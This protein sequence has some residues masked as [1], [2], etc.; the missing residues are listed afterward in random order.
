[1][2]LPRPVW[3]L[4]WVSFFTDTASEMIYPLMPLFLTRVLG[5]G[6]M[7]LGVIEGIAE[8]ANSVLKIVSGR[9][10]DRSG[11]PKRLVLAGYGLSSALR[12]FIAM[13][14]GWLQVLALRFGDRLGKG[15]RTS[16]RDA[17]LA[18]FADESNRGRIFGFHRGMDHAGAV[19]GPLVAATFLYF[20]P[21]D[22]RTL[23]ALTIVPGII[24]ILIL[25]RVP[26]TQGAPQDR[27]RSDG[28][29]PAQGPGE[30]RLPREFHRAMAIVFLF[31]LGNAS[32]AFLL[33]RFADVGIAS[34]WIPLLWSGIHVVKT[35]SS[36]SG[37]RVSDRLGRRQ[38]I[39]VG[40]LLYAAVYAAFAVTDSAAMLIVVFL[41]Y[42][43]YFGLT[44]GVEKAWVADLAPES[45]RGIAFGIYNALIGFGAL[46]ASLLFG[47]VWTRVSP[48]AAFFTGAGF[49]LAATALLYLMFSSDSGNAAREQ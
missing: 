29:R 21:D 2:P 47:F 32:D 46:G 11:A 15:I 30:R 24:V 23:F 48:H 17:M 14:T 34:F 19:M 28:H 42:G 27:L 41:I 39:G 18:T 44:E 5:A 25:L 16:P 12:P 40:W 22:Y 37:G 43:L 45:G 7:S 35:T 31:S 4:G 33:L 6:A 1:M 9:M 3:Q 10:V 13:A 49:A 36:V 38:V 20:R 8:A 26:D